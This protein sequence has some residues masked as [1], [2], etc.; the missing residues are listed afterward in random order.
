MSV[1]I[2]I[3][4]SVSLSIICHYLSVIIYLSVCRSVC[5]SIIYLSIHLSQGSL[6]AWILPSSAH[7]L[8]LTHPGNTHR[9][10]CP[11]EAHSPV[12]SGHMGSP[13]QSP[14]PKCTRHTHMSPVG[15]GSAT[16]TRWLAVQPELIVGRSSV[17]SMGPESADIQN[18]PGPR[19]PA[20]CLPRAVSQAQLS[21]TLKGR[22]KGVVWG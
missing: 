18:F 2:S 10:T 19:W 1:S 12:G 17:V 8:T 7:T 11:P 21:Q 22:E 9:E 3:Y 20:G 13:Q 5:L 6:Q 14:H 4:K 15:D 16:P